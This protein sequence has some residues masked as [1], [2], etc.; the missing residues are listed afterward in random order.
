MDY[1]EQRLDRRKNGSKNVGF[2]NFGLRFERR[3]LP[4]R[5]TVERPRTRQKRHRHRHVWTRSEERRVGKEC[6][7]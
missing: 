2:V 5:R 7:W 6:S 1:A 3:G 4:D